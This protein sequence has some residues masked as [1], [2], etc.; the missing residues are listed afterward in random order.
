MTANVHH[1]IESSLTN[2]K[3]RQAH[4][5]F[6]V[7]A[8][9]PH[10]FTKLQLPITHQSIAIYIETFMANIRIAGQK[11]PL[12][13]PMSVV[14]NT[15]IHIYVVKYYHGLSM[16]SIFCFWTTWLIRGTVGLTL[17]HITWIQAQDLVWVSLGPCLWL[18]KIDKYIY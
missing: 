5:C 7:A 16:S 11:T 3:E 18:Q 6:F 2:K 17:I 14:K 12:T 15:L 9:I 10:T 13:A 4:T 1:F 8:D